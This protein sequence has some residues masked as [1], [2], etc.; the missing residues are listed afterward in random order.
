MLVSRTK[1]E[2]SWV[3]IRDDKIWKSNGVKLLGVTIDNQLKF[4]GNIA[5]GYLFQS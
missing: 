5:N 1:Y 4:D 3:K 2:H